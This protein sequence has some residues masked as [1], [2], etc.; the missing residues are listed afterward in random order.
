MSGLRGRL[1][2][3]VI[4]IDQ[5]LSIEV[6]PQVVGKTAL[7]FLKQHTWEYKKTQELHL[8]TVAVIL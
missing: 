3:K 6:P 2:E 4:D 8:A 5:K 7:V 1:D